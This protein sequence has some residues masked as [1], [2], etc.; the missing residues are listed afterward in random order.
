MMKSDS[1]SSKA[2]VAEHVGGQGWKLTDAE[3]KEIE[4]VLME[5]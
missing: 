5:E 2:Q 3:L 4:A 1:N